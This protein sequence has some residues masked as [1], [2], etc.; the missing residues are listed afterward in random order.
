MYEDGSSYVNLPMLETRR[1]EGDLIEVFKIYK[2]FDDL[3]LICF[4]TR[5]RFRHVVFVF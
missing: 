3:D 5:I 1:P 2:G 4:L